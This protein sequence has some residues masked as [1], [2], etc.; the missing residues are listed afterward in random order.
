[1]EPSHLASCKILS[2]A[3][4]LVGLRGRFVQELL[5]QV[6]L[7]FRTHLPVNRIA[8]LLLSERTTVFL[9]G[10]VEFGYP[11]TGSTMSH[12]PFHVARRPALASRRWARRLSILFTLRT[13]QT[14]LVADSTSLFHCDNQSLQSVGYSVFPS[15]I[16]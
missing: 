9:N 16:L 2:I 14:V 8:K 13:M 15:L 12:C 4:S 3:M 11:F 10:T 5:Q 1:M 6:P 7:A